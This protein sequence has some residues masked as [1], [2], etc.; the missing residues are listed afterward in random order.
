MFSRTKLSI[1]HGMWIFVI[2]WTSTFRNEPQNIQMHSKNLPYHFSFKCNHVFS[3]C[4]HRKSNNITVMSE[5]QHQG[6][7]IENPQ[8]NWRDLIPL[9]IRWNDIEH[10]AR[11]RPGHT[12]ENNMVYPSA[13]SRYGEGLNYIIVRPN[14]LLYK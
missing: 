1:I 10:C 6:N 7:V 2:L 3:I 5:T 13:N 9:S 12:E 14:P 4:H 11:E 8:R